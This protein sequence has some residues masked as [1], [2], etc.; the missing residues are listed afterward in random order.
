MLSADL[1]SQLHLLP[2]PVRDV[3]GEAAAQGCSKHVTGHATY[4]WVLH[5]QSLLVWKA[6]DGA[7]ATVRRLTLPRPPVGGTF[8]EVLPQRQSTALTV[9]VCTAAGWLHVWLDATFGGEPFNQQVVKG[10]DGDEPNLICAL[11]ATPADA[12][13]SPAFLAVIA[14]ADAALHLY[15]GSQ[16]GIFPRQFYNPRGAASTQGGVFQA[17]TIAVGTAKKVAVDY[18]LLVGIPH[19]RTSASTAPAMQLQLLQL[20]SNRWKLFVL[21]R[22]AESPDQAQSHAL[23]CWLLG[24]LSGKQSSEQLLWSL[25]VHQAVLGRSRVSHHRVL[26]FTASAAPAQQQLPIAG[27]ETPGSA[28]MRPSTEVIYVWSSSMLADSASAYQHTCSAFA[29]EDGPRQGPRL[30]LTAVIPTAAAMPSPKLKQRW[31]LLAHGQ[32]PSCLLLAPNGVLVE[33]L[34]TAGGLP[35]VLSGN[36]TNVAIASSGHNSN[37][38]ILNRE[39]G[40]LEFTAHGLPSSAPQH[41]I[42]EYSEAAGWCRGVQDASMALCSAAHLKLGR[43]CCLV[44]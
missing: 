9:I 28:P 31:Q 5:R 11:A 36:E 33:W 12:G 19:L 2:R 14:T 15:H 20:D 42:G 32:L 24:T 29:V 26:G 22:S 18:N 3:I 23:D 38:Q 40:V 21:T 8:V 44:C 35:N 37:W 13:A 17:I 10:S 16:N 43:I 1:L 25:D 41:P 4:A 39:F 30:I 34:R 7:A 27:Q 6:E